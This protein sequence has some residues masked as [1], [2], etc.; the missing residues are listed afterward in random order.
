MPRI[1]RYCLLLTLLSQRKVKYLFAIIGDCEVIHAFPTYKIS[2]TYYVRTRTSSRSILIIIQTPVVQN[3]SHFH[4]LYF[5]PNPVN[6]DVGVL[7]DFHSPLPTKHLKIIQNPPNNACLLP[8]SPG[9]KRRT[10]LTSRV[11][12]CG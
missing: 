10:N 11:W 8:T 12:P 7:S 1:I 6:V 5:F 2:T 3:T 9:C 4:H